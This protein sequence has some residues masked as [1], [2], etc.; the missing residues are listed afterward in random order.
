MIFKKFDFLQSHEYNWQG[1]KAIITVVV[2]V[3]DIFAFPSFWEGFG[4]A[5]AEGMSAGL[6]AVGF[7]T[8][9]GV[10]EL[11]KDGES[12]YLCEDNLEAFTD[13][14]DKLMSDKDLR[15]KMGRAAKESMKQFA[16][17]KNWDKWESLIMNAVR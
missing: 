16:P 8:C 11:I 1:H 15:V 5:L 14:L 9:P 2:Q 7:K 3:S 10:N 4:L 12:G 13:A 6:P 17:Q